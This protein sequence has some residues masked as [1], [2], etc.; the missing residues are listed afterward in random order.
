[1]IGRHLEIVVS[2]TEVAQPEGGDIEVAVYGQVD[3]HHLGGGGGE[4]GAVLKV[5]GVVEVV[6]FGN[7]AR[8]F[9]A[10]RPADLVGVVGADS[11]DEFFAAVGATGAGRRRAGG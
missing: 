9:V 8:G 11:G 3:L 5:D 2:K 4:V 1:M 7:P 10:G 6:I